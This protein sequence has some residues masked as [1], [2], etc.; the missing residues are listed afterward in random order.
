[1]LYYGVGALYD[2]MGSLD[3]T[4]VDSMYSAPDWP[5]LIGFYVLYAGLFG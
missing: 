4:I 2:V 1:M 3:G 5:F